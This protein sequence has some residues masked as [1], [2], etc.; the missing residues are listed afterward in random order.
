MSKTWV[1]PP[2]EKCSQRWRISSIFK[3]LFDLVPNYPA[4]VWAFG[5]AVLEEKKTNR[6]N[7]KK[8]Q[9][10]VQKCLET[11]PLIFSMW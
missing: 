8:A 4:K 2:A 11:G 9:S 6:E 7:A 1:S 3:K 5:A 10:Y